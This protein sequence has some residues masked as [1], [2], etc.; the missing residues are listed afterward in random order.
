MQE[1]RTVSSFPSSSPASSNPCLNCGACCANFR[2]SFYWAEGEGLPD[3][4]V[5]RLTPIMACMRGSN[6]RAPRCA[7]LQGE[8]GD[9]VGCTVYAHRPSP[10]REVLAGDAKCRQA[11]AA[12]G[13]LP[14]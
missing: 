2:V 14:L 3:E 12:Y 7:A 6:S 10:C 9:A 1:S 8:V 11:R 5:E 13:L 4:L